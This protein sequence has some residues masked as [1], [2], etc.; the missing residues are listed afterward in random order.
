MTGIGRWRAL[1]GAGVAL[2][3]ALV[4]AAAWRAG[5]PYASAYARRTA[6]TVASYLSLVTPPAR[7]GGP[8]YDLAPLLIQAR[9]LASL[10]GLRA[11]V[12][13]YHRTAPLVHATAAALPA[14]AFERLRRRETAEWRDGRALAPLKDRDDWD[15]VGAVTVR[16]RDLGS[17]LTSA[18]LLLGVAI[19]LAG[20]WVTVRGLD[21]PGRGVVVLHAA[22][23]VALGLG[24]YAGVRGAAREST[25]RWLTDTRA[26]VQ[27]IV[28]R[29]PRGRV[30][31]ASM[32]RLVPGATLL[33]A[34]SARAAPRRERV[35]QRR[36]AVVAIRLAAG[37]W[38][39]LRTL[40]AEAR[41]GGWLVVLVA[42]GLVG[43]GVTAVARWGAAAAARPREMKETVT[44]WG[45]LA[46][47]ATHLA[48]L[49]FG[50]MLFTL[51]VS[52]HRWSLLEPDRPFVGIR[53]FAGVLRDP[54]VW[55][56]LKNTVLYTLYVPATMALAL[57]AALA[58][59]RGRRG[60]RLVRTALFLPTVSSVVAIALV[61]QWMFNADFG[62]INWLLS[63][64][65]RPAVDW[66]GHPGTAL[67][68]V[69]LVS[70]WVQIGYQMV[71]FLA[72][73]QGIPDAYHDAARVDGAGP[74]QRFRYV[75]LPLLRPVILF[76][77]V[78]G[79]IGSFQV[80]TY[81]YVLTDG[82]PL[83]A[84]DVIVYR[85]YQSA[86]EFLQFGYASA[87]ALLLFAVLFGAT[88]AQFRLLGRRVEYA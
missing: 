62:I 46:P 72:G 24:A 56:S 6:T 26:L 49:G 88:W 45:F 83:H 61:W 20:G 66:L 17:P 29:A 33:A 53:N 1:A 9:G 70:G 86:W 68:A 30:T 18:A 52:T 39:E 74:W 69:M 43:P 76:V 60:T 51:Y 38:L 23:G 16:P 65:G 31:V 77:L 41:T 73:L 3:L 50:P 10:P 12:E 35:G 42:L 27:D 15:V 79:V 32:R 7:G 11:D 59:H 28:A 37:R 55:L 21:R 78:T 57:A 47:A 4:L 40:P 82:G 48:V 44:A 5:D 2:S 85:I 14:R 67:L 87:L 36:L 71:V 19:A 75:T 81:I 58:L 8:G 64:A 22:T 63:L 25:D 54:L 34:D 80:F 13:V 84:T